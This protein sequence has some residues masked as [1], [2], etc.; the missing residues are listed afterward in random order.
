MQL[1]TPTPPEEAAEPSAPWTSKT[2]TTAIKAQSQSEYL[3]RRIRRHKSSSP[4]SIIE[5]LK[6]ST[7]ATKAALHQLALVEA[8]LKNLEEANRILSRRRRAKKTRLQK[9]GTMTV[10]EA[11]QVIDQMD[12]DMQVVAESSRSGGRGRS[13]RPGGRHCGVCGKGG[14]NARTCQE[15]LESSGKEFSE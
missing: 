9:G 2:P 10:Q 1:R 6:S 3:E 5:A 7:K 14:H 15:V 8:R 4:E 12:V 13:E 11:S